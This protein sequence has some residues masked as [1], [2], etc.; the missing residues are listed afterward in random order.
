[1]KVIELLILL[2][3]GCE[4]PQLICGNASYLSTWEILLWHD[5]PRCVCHDFL[6]PCLDVIA[7]QDGVT[8]KPESG[9]G[10]TDMASVQLL[11]NYLNRGIS[12]C[13]FYLFG[14]GSSKDISKH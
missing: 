7:V 9:F 5:L 11:L 3:V 13:L 8:C 6:D 4:G 10:L 2:C 14:S 1:M 12:Y